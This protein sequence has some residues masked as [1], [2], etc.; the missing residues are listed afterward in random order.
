MLFNVYLTI[1]EPTDGS[2]S[3]FKVDAVPAFGKLTPHQQWVKTEPTHYA[4]V[5]GPTEAKT[6]VGIIAQYNNTTTTFTILEHAMRNMRITI[7]LLKECA[8]IM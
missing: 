4:Q 2:D 7:P 6:Y 3:T 8:P 1:I 5:N